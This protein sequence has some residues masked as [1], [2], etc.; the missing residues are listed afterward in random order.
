MRRRHIVGGAAAAITA[1]APAGAQ[2]AAP[3]ATQ[4]VVYHV[5]ADG[6]PDGRNWRIL[7]NN[8]ENHIEAVGRGNISLVAVLN[9]GGL[10]LLRQAMTEQDMQRRITALKQAGVRFQVCR[11]TMRGMN[12]TLAD[13]YDAREED[14][15]AAGVVELVRWQQQGYAYLRP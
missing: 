11:N 1:A 7:L 5:T 2:Q 14:V 10:G 15:I 13:L 3:A 4:K 12:L 6:G 8:M 9:A